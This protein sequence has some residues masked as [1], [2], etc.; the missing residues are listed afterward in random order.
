[1]MGAGRAAPRVS[2][3]YLVSSTSDSSAFAASAP[4]G[5]MA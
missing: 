3:P 2:G 1:M 4:L 5:E